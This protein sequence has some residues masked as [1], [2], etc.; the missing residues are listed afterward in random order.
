[1]GQAQLTYVNY[2]GSSMEPILKP[3][4]LLQVLAYSGSPVRRGDVIFYSCPSKN[5]N[6]V[7]RV[8]NFDTRGIRTRGDNNARIDP[9]V[10]GPKQVVGYVAHAQRGRRWRL[11]SGG[12]VGHFVA[13]LLHAA[14]HFSLFFSGALYPLYR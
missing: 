8:T 7:H 1:M 13:N 4:D 12:L 11:I 6:I 2:T 5:C 10:V 14:K 9:W 3:G